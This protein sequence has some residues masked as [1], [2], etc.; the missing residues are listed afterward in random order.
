MKL[1][2]AADIVCYV[3]NVQES[4]HFYQ[5][6]GFQV[7]T[8]NP[9]RVSAYLNWFWIV[10]LPVDQ[11]VKPAGEEEGALGSIGSGLF[12]YLSVDHVDEAYR[13][14]LA[15]GLTPVCEPRNRPGG[16]R[17]FILPDPDG[18]QLVISKVIGRPCAR[19]LL[20]WPRC[21][22]AGTSVASSAST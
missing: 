14:L 21:S 15:Q 7:K 10:F 20:A 13:E 2:S 17:E 5:T 19:V 16:I 4:A 12:L 3:K 1:K 8:R 18:Y 6:L 22:C 9:D 11:V